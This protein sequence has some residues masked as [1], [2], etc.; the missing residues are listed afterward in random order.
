MYACTKDRQLMLVGASLWGKHCG[1]KALGALNYGA[2]CVMDYMVLIIIYNIDAFL[3]ILFLFLL[4]IVA[5]CYS[6]YAY[7]LLSIISLYLSV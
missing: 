6:I 3:V 1:F 5:H 7:L 2:A 4:N